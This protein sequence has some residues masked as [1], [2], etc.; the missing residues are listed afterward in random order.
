MI[1]ARVLAGGTPEI[2]EPDGQMYMIREGIE[3]LLGGHVLVSTGSYIETG[4][5]PNST[6]FMSLVKPAAAA[7]PIAVPT[8]ASASP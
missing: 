6:D 8:V 5:T 7:S 1:G 4:L 3:A 2:P